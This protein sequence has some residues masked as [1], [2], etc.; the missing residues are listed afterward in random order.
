M[1]RESAM[2]SVPSNSIC[3]VESQH[4]PTKGTGAIYTL[5]LTKGDKC[6]LFITSSQVL[7]I[8][9]KEE[10]TGLKL[11]FEEN[12][13]QNPTPDWVDR[14]WISPYNMTV[15]ELSTI[16]MTVLS[17]T[18]I[19]GLHCSPPLV[20]EPIIIYQYLGERG[21]GTIDTIDDLYISYNINK[22]LDSFGCLL[23]NLSFDVVGIVNLLIESDENKSNKQSLRAIQLDAIFEAYRAYLEELTKQN[24]V[25]KDWLTIIN[26]IPKELVGCGGYGKVYKATKADGNKIALKVVERFGGLGA[27]KTEADALQKEFELVKSLGDHPHIIKFFD[28][29]RDDDNAKLIIVMEYLEGRSLAEKIKS[30]VNLNKMTCLRYLV[31]IL[32]GLTFVH[33][34]KVYHSD[35]K[36]ENLLLTKNDNIK[37]CDFGISVQIHSN[38]NTIATSSHAKGAFSYYMSPERLNGASRS[39]E[40]DIWSV[41]ATF[42]TMITGNKLN[43]NQANT[44]APIKIAAYEIFIGGKSINQF[45]DDLSKND[46]RR[47]IIS[48][49][50]CPVEMRLN[51][52]ALLNIC[53]KLR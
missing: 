6:T 32:E 1:N 34:N 45:L 50:L 33:A 52:N 49:T 20:K 37:I 36:P 21:S 12:K 28:F 24:S 5:H 53:I 4:Y 25:N 8:S 42:V 13:I 11:T 15:I 35:I 23:L 27:Y 9:N 40:N 3:L 14:L 7:P 30:E 17:S 29:V 26:T 31:H 41:G 44:L 43:H 47:L 2:E 22:Y 38:S 51:S 46:Y 10:I 19:I 48:K 16:A 18:N 39:A